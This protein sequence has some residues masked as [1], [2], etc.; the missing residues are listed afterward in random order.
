MTHILIY[1]ASGH[2]KVVAAI[3]ES[4]GISVEGFL[5]DHMSVS[6][7]IDKPVNPANSSEIPVFLGIGSNLVRKKIV[8]TKQLLLS[9]ALVDATSIIR[10]KLPLGKGTLVGPAAVINPDAKIGRFVIINT[11]AVVEHDCIIGD[12]AHISPNATLSGSVTIGEGVHIGSGAVII[13]GITVGDWSVVG[14]GSV[15]IKDVPANT[16]IAGNPGRMISS[17]GYTPRKSSVR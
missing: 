15:I 1:G 6:Q 9:D 2:G 16:T 13:P 7:Y 4:S 14:A 12:Y 11:A 10:T 8:E 17:N 5:D 3:A